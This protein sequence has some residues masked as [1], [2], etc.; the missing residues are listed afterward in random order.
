MDKRALA[1]SRKDVLEELASELEGDEN[2]LNRIAYLIVKV[3]SF[4]RLIESVDGKRSVAGFVR[5]LFV[6]VS[7]TALTLLVLSTAYVNSPKASIEA[8]ASGIQ[9]RN[10]LDPR[11]DLEEL[12]FENMHITKVRG[13][14]SLYT[15]PLRSS[16]IK[17][18]SSRDLYFA[19][20]ASISSASASGN[21]RIDLEPIDLGKVVLR[22]S[23]SRL[24]LRIS[25][26][27]IPPCWES[28]VQVCPQPNQIEKVSDDPGVVDIEGEA[29][30]VTFELIDPQA[31]N[32]TAPMLI[33]TRERSFASADFFRRSNFVGEA[34]KGRSQIRQAKI[35]FVDLDNHRVDVGYGQALKLSGLTGSIQVEMIGRYLK[36]SFFGLMDGAVSEGNDNLNPTLL[37]Y[38]MKS[39]MLGFLTSAFVLVFGWISWVSRNLFRYGEDL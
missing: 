12:R 36:L 35:Q 10:E 25:H 19:T 6:F 39:E 15:S 23:G 4:D 7:L 38:L 11:W 3:S 21:S 18:A 16:P 33:S 24:K 30:E 5:S 31:E 37:T 26:G 9:L 17:N 20:G 28:D 32:H 29:L 1:N 22:I 8:T 14:T 13:I 2:N 34:E 27:A